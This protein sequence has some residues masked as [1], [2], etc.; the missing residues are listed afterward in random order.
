M[1]K[2]K[3][4]IK[5]DLERIDKLTDREID[6]SDIPELDASFFTRTVVTLPHKKDSVTLRIDHEVLEFFKQ[7]GARYQTRIN[8][9]LKAYVGV[10]R[11]L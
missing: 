11:K 8:A 6:Y 3:K 5:S 1:P 9:V 10:H 7:Q 4:S 2:N